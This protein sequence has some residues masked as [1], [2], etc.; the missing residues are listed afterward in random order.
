MNNEG[1]DFKESNEKN[2]S[3]S[4]I[5]IDPSAQH[6]FKSFYYGKNISDEKS[7]HNYPSK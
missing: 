7:Q 6:S 2:E 4:C 5:Y 1:N 3:N